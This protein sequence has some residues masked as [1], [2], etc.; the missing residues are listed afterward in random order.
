[1]LPNRAVTPGATWP[2]VTELDL[3]PLGKHLI[4]R[5]LRYEGAQNGLDRIGMDS[6]VVHS[7]FP[8]QGF[9]VTAAELKDTRGSGTL[10]FDRRLGRIVEGR[11]E[12]RFEATLTIDIGGMTTSVV[13][14]QKDEVRFST[15]DD[16][17]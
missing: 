1:M 2:N 7:A 8:A 12:S 6:T 10:W 5:V 4:L 17:R 3:G 14:S 13:L 11:L 9:K 15:V 16:V